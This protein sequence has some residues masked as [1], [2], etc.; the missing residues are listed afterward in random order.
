MLATLSSEC[1]VAFPQNTVERD[2]EDHSS[3]LVWILGA[4]SATK[5]LIIL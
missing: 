3:G 1:L 5:A 4:A 2:G